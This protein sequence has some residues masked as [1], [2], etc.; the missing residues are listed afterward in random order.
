MNLYFYKPHKPKEG[1]N[2]RMC[3][4]PL[5]KDYILNLHSEEILK[6]V[7]KIFRFISLNAYPVIRN[8]LNSHV[9]SDIPKI[10]QG[11]IYNE[12]NI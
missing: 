4:D 8:V 11:L 1:N 7:F 5:Y 10:I 2:K 3:I 9:E 6:E 12:L